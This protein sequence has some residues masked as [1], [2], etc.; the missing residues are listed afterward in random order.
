MDFSTRAKD[1]ITGLLADEI[2]R[3]VEGGEIQNQVEL[4]NGIRAL[5]QQVG[6]QTYG[7][8]LEREDEKQGRRVGC[9]CGAQAPRIAKR[10]AQI[11][12]VLGWVGYHRSYYG[13]G[14]C[15]RKH[16]RLDQR[17][18]LH[19]GE[20][21]PVMG[22][23]LAIA[24][25]D[26][27]FE[28]AQ[29]K[30]REF[31]LVEVSDNTIRKQTQ[32]IGQKQ[33]QLEAE[34]VRQSQDEAWLQERERTMSAVPQR[35]Y[36]SL[37]GAQVPV[38]QEWRELKTLSWYQVAEVYGRAEPKAQAISYHSAIA[39]AEE[40]GRLLWATGV[41]RLADKAQELIF[42]CDG[43][44]W[45]WKLISHYFPDA[46]QIVDWYH[47]CE[48]LTPIADAVFSQAAAR[49][50]WLEQVKN[51]LWQGQ[52]QKVIAACQRYGRHKT[53]GEAAQRAST[54]YTN[55]QHRMN[56]AQFRAQGYWIGSG[57]VESA[58]KQIATARL[59]ISGARWTLAG[60]IATAK[61]RA[62]WLSDGAAFDSLSLLPLAV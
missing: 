21:S 37:D 26:I 24:G 54:Y 34:W 41:R 52:A 43:A 13:C 62:A 50:K 3:L 30:I 55:N 46:I 51:W 27:A 7:K 9:A 6:Q 29:R 57:T 49:Q 44:V 32:Q 56:Y 42:V 4:E 48:Y 18:G 36:G 35:L 12:S 45:I 38:G 39:P 31:L 33:A 53:A 10:K 1:E 58:C 17:W 40:F 25:V 8:V 59:K 23:L 11:L 5:L 20:V 2:S 16:Y 60:A 15:G 22:K 28:R 61:A 14:A 47:A 19:P